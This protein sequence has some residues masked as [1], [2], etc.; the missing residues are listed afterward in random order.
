MKLYGP[1]AAAVLGLSKDAPSLG[2]GMFTIP[3]GTK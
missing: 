3:G 1:S 2:V